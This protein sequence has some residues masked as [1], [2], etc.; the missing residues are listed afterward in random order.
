MIASVLMVSN[1]SIACLRA[2]A[3]EHQARLLNSGLF[4]Q[5]RSFADLQ[6]RHHQQQQQQQQQQQLYL[7]NT[8]SSKNCD[9]KSCKQQQFEKG[10]NMSTMSSMSKEE[11][12]HDV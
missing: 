5:V 1:N 7:N 8:N 12:K 10:L 4:L 6:Q 9:I 3:Q 2:K 11:G